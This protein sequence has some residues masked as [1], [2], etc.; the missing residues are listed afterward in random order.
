MPITNSALI[1]LPFLGLNGP[2]GYNKEPQPR[3]R[4]TIGFFL[5]LQF[6]NTRALRTESLEVSPTRIKYPSGASTQRPT[7]RARQGR[8]CCYSRFTEVQSIT[9]QKLPPAPWRQ[10]GAW[11]GRVGDAGWGK[12]MTASPPSATDRLLSGKGEMQS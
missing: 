11:C 12:R 4:L 9:S 1:D 6:F 7:C 8:D 3:F 10:E 2:K 5:H